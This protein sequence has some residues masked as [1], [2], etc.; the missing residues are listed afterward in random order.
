MGKSTLESQ[1]EKVRYYC[2]RQDSA[3]IFALLP[4]QALSRLQLTIPILAELDDSHE[5]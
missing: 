3:F 5:M 1:N 4:L 2:D